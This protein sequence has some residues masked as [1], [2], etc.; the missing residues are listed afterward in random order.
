MEHHIKAEEKQDTSKVAL[1][2]NAAV[3][4]LEDQT[5]IPRTQRGGR[6]GT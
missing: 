3:A 4:N 1:C 2:V 6:R 5:S